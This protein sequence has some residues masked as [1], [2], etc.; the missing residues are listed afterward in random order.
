MSKYRA[1]NPKIWELCLVPE[2]S[3]A[4]SC[5]QVCW[6]WAVHRSDYSEVMCSKLFQTAFQISIIFWH[7]ITFHRIL[8]QCHQNTFTCTQYSQGT[9][10]VWLQPNLLNHPCGLINRTPYEVAR[11]LNQILICIFF[12]NVLFFLP[13]APPSPLFSC[14][15]QCPGS[16]RSSQIEEES[17][18]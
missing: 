7:R 2:M 12:R 18:L 11:T 3:M 16:N 8:Y 14:Y 5:W 10:W 6:G 9:K 1:K 17:Y 4:V 13:P 15:L